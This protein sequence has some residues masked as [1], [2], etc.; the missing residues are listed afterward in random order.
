MTD[1]RKTIPLLAVSSSLVAFVLCLLKRREREKTTRSAR[2][3]V[4]QG[5][6]VRSKKNDVRRMEL[7]L[8]YMA[9]D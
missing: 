3:M 6:M 5:P 2:Q 4:K 1:Q 9:H 7:C 8:F